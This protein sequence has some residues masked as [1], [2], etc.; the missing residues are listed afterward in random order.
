MLSS[1]SSSYDSAR[2][3]RSSVGMDVLRSPSLRK[4]LFGQNHITKTGELKWLVSTRCVGTT[5]NSA[6]AG[7]PPIE[8]ADDK[9]KR[10]L[11][12]WREN[13]FYALDG[14]REAIIQSFMRWDAPQSRHFV[15]GN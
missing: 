5:K 2:K 11:S 9:H 12:G 3:L 10:D 7:Q 8:K 15:R 13:N 14:T 1:S 6:R 4:L